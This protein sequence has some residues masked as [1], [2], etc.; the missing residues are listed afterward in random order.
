MYYIFICKL[1]LYV[2]LKTYWNMEILCKNN[3]GTF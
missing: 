1:R 2:I 3:I